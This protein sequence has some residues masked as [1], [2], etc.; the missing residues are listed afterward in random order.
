MPALAAVLAKPIAHRGLH[1]RAQGRI[2]NSVPAA[3]A[4]IAAGF[5]IECDIQASADGEAM[6]FHDA[7][8]DRLTHAAGRVDATAAAD[9]V[10]L[11][12]KSGGGATIPTL[13]GFLAAIGGRVP[14]VIEI[15]SEGDGRA[16]ALASR[17]VALVSTYRG[18]VALKSFDPF[19]VAHCRDEGA[20]CPLGLVGPADVGG[21]ADDLSLYDF[22]SW[23]VGR[24][25]DL[26]RRAPAKPAMSWTIRS[27]EDQARAEAFGAQIVFEGFQP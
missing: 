6:V 17:A 15:K 24:L 3:E 9:L 10:R 13:A 25:D 11:P 23:N 12:L 14:L 27:P 16:L 1:D 2:E 20:P 4:A 26:R 8:L 5:G 21:E 18:V 19:V 22:L 7:T